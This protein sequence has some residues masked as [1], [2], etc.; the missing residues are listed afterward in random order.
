M[1]PQCPE[2]SMVLNGASASTLRRHWSLMKHPPKPRGRPIEDPFKS[3]EVTKAERARL[4]NKVYRLIQPDLRKGS[5]K[6]LKPNVKA[7]KQPT[8]K[9]VKAWLRHYE[10]I[11]GP[12]LKLS[13]VQK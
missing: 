11:Y 12:P 7:P 5:K 1:P 3:G 8:S 2:C 13:D 4:Y 10:A 6:I 9:A